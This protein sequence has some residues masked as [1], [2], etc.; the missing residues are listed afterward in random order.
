MSCLWI[1]RSS[2]LV[3]FS[4]SLLMLSCLGAGAQQAAVPV[5]VVKAQLS[6]LS[7][8]MWVPGTIVSENNSLLSFEVSGRLTEFRRIGSTLSKG[9]VIA[10]I[11][12]ELLRLKRNELVAAVN[13][14]QFR[15]QYLQDEL[16][17]QTQL[18]SRDL[19]AESAIDKIGS[20]YKSAT[21]ALQEANARL[22]QAEKQ[23]TLSVLYAPFEGVITERLGQLGEYVDE[24]TPMVR[25]V[26]TKNL[27]VKAYVPVRFFS[28]IDNDST[29]TLKSH[30]GTSSPVSLNTLVPVAGHRSHQME[31]RLHTEGLNWPVGLDVRVAVPINKKN[32]LVTVPRDALVIR[33][34]GISV[35]RV[36]ENNTVQQLSVEVGLSDA[37]SIEVIGGVK[38][39][40]QIVIR[41]AER[42]SEGQAVRIKS[43]NDNLSIR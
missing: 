11:D 7:S 20:E 41:G 38:P 18:L 27:E 29:F 42:L 17:R 6:A 21:S 28:F 34:E 14:A 19:I 12:D 10:R 43:N 23:L 4:F 31:L 13:S 26:A 35:F 40:D 1:K 2:G 25:F 15:F 3:L 5:N 37:R 39:D 22:A 32:Q 24:Q 33:P 8:V 9:E 30:L 16:Q 36:L